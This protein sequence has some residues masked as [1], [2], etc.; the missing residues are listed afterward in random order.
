VELLRSHGFIEQVRGISSV[1]EEQHGR[2]APAEKA[3]GDMTEEDAAQ[4]TTLVLTEQ[5]D[6]VE[7][8]REFRMIVVGI[9]LPL[10][11]TDQ[12]ARRIF[13]DH[14]EPASVRRLERLSPLIL[15]HLVGW[16][17]PANG[18]VSLVEG[19]HVKSGQGGNVHRRRIPKDG[20][21]HFLL[22]STSQALA[23]GAW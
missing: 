6:L 19:R 20:G 1:P 10:G 22:P 17:I 23:D 14:T 16:P 9:G 11:E 15:S 18:G 7:L 2:D 13:D 5:V 12:L 21:I 8:P 4:T 3:V